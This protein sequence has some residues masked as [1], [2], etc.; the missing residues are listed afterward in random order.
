VLQPREWV[1]A[2]SEQN[3]AKPPTPDPDP[4][5]DP[6]DESSS[7]SDDSDS[8]AYG[9]DEDDYPLDELDI[10][11]S[12]AFHLDIVKDLK[13]PLIPSTTQIM[14]GFVRTITTK[15][16]V[17]GADNLIL[18]QKELRTTAPIC[19]KKRVKGGKSSLNRGNNISNESKCF[20]IMIRT[21]CTH[22]KKWQI[23]T[24]TSL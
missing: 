13:I 3:Q 23:Q 8:E 12:N 21:F 14:K 9:F 18:P 11:T 2:L 6:S 17:S 15:F 7:S 20:A 10:G 19:R 1:Q 24:S 22:C 16:A 5:D 4:S